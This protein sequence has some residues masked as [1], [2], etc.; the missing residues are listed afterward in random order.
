MRRQAS[1]PA[2][3]AVL[4]EGVT[5][6]RVHLHRL[7]ADLNRVLRLVESSNRREHL[8]E[9]AGDL[10]QRMPQLMTDSLRSLDSLRSF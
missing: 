3:W 9:V 7:Q 10:I 2:A 1:S 6:T 8:Y 4:T 5:E